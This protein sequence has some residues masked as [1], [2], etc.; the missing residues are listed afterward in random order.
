MTIV[1]WFEQHWQ[2]VSAY[3]PLIRLCDDSRCVIDA[4][5]E[6]VDRYSPS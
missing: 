4:A 6:V 5:R 1:G 3:L 2:V